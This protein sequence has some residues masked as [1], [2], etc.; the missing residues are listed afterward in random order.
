MRSLAA[1]QAREA[2][3]RRAS[4]DGV[5]L[6]AAALDPERRRPLLARLVLCNDQLDAAS[7]MCAMA[8]DGEG[9]GRVSLEEAS[10]A[11]AAAQT[12]LLD[13][14]ARLRSE[15]THFTS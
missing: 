10:A 6:R 15:K 11:L 8:E 7:R 2:L 12:S 1:A 14:Y 4:A 13:L 3:L 5:P 9:G